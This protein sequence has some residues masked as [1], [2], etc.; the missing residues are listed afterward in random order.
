VKLSNAKFT[1]TEILFNF[2]DGKGAC[3]GDSG[4]PAFAVIN[5][6]LFVIGVTSRAPSLSGGETCLE[7]AVYTSVPAHIEFLRQSAQYLNSSKF[8][9]DEKIPQPEDVQ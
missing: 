7:G 4:G 2:M 9:E 5:G 6:K 8:V 1:E 3:H